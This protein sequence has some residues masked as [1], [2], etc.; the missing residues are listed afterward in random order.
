[1]SKCRQHPI[2][3][4]LQC[5]W[6]WSSCH[7]EASAAGDLLDGL[8]LHTRATPLPS[9]NLR[10]WQRNCRRTFTCCPIC[11]IADSPDAFTARGAVQEGE[12]CDDGGSQRAVE[13]CGGAEGADGHLHCRQW[14]WQQWLCLPR[15]PRLCPTPPCRQRC[16]PGAVPAVFS[17]Y[18]W[19]QLTCECV[20]T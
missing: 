15:H 20:Q 2:Q 13:G 19:S 18:F 11:L 16:T 6:R 10:T 1:M 4:P 14:Q 9:V 17:H 5:P 3:E 7:F 8:I 12:Q